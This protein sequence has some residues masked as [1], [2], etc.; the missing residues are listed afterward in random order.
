MVSKEDVFI[1]DV[2][3]NLQAILKTYPA[4]QN[5]QVVMGFIEMVDLIDQLESI[6]A[7]GEKQKQGFGFHPSL[8]KEENMDGKEA[9]EHAKQLRAKLPGLLEWLEAS[10]DIAVAA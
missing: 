1:R 3:S 5:I 8:K 7:E 4:Y 10:S 9:L 2:A 6:G